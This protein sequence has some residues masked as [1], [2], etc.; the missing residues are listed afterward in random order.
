[1][2]DGVGVVRASLLKELLEVVQGRPRLT[3]A[4][5]CDSHGMHH[6]GAAYLLVNAIIIIGHCCG[7]LMVLLE[8]LLAALGS[9]LSILD[10]DIGRQFPG[11]ALGSVKLGCI[12]VDGVLGCGAMQLSLVSLMV[13]ADARKGRNSGTSRAPLLGT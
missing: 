1:V 3:L 13:S 4:T 10:D 8:T 2:L 11:P 12:V 9:L 5:V 7:F 6:D